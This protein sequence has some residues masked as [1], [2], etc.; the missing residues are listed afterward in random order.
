MSSGSP[1]PLPGRGPLRTGRATFTASGSSK[2]PWA[3]E[4]VGQRC[5]CVWW[6]MTPPPSLFPVG[7]QCRVVRG[8]VGLDHLVT[9]NRCPRQFPPVGAR[10][11]VTE[12]PTVLPSRMDPSEVAVHDPL[13]RLRVVLTA[14]P[15]E[16]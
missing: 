6:P 7:G 8:R 1:G 3:S 13:A 15:F 12:D 5:W 9:A 11:P 16:Q 14:A 2:F 4:V 10:C